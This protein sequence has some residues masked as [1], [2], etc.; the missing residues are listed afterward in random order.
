MLAALYV[1][2]LYALIIGKGNIGREICNTSLVF[3]H[4]GG[5][6]IFHNGNEFKLMLRRKGLHALKRKHGSKSLSKLLYNSSLVDLKGE[7]SLCTADICACADDILTL[8]KHVAALMTCYA[9]IIIGSK[10]VNIH[11]NSK[12]LAFSGS[13]E[14]CLFKAAEHLCRLAQHSLRSAGIELDNFLARI[15]ACVLDGNLYSYLAVIQ[16]RVCNSMLKSCI[17]EAEAERILYLF[18]SKCLK[19]S[20]AYVNILAVEIAAG[21]AEI[22]VRGVIGNGVRNGVRQFSRG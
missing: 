17:G 5:G 3:V 13:K 4:L 6:N 14:L 15:I 2:K 7:C 19:I 11:I 18:G 12:Y 9:R 16:L 8:F 20:V 1:S 10:V 22:L 21:I